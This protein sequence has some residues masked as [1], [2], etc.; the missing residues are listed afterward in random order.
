MFNAFDCSAPVYQYTAWKNGH[1]YRV[2]VGM[3]GN[4]VGVREVF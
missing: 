2:K 4:I 3:S 1:K